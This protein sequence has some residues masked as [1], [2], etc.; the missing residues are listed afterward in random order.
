ML[1]VFIETN[2]VVDYAAPAHYRDSTAVQ[3]LE[4]AR[5][6][7]FRLHL[8]SIC[9]SE[10]RPP[11]RDKPQS[12]HVTTIR[13]FLKWAGKH[14]LVAA[15]DGDATRRVLNLFQG[16]V[17]ADLDELDHT[18]ESLAR[19]S[20]LDVFPLDT[21]MLE[22]TISLTFEKL[23]LGPFDQAVLAAVLVRSEVLRSE[24]ETEFA[25]CELDA[26]LQPWDKEN[27]RKEPLASLYDAAYVWV[28]GDFALK[29]PQQPGGWPGTAASER[30]PVDN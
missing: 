25:F 2:W 30:R 8:P 10:A 20:A 28:Y 14:A 15:E 23:V 18:L 26:H 21:A 22:K 17:R 24:G 27:N 11:I 6:G 13:D 3:L 7:E 19:E 1:H 16:R 5:S 12:R 4:R 9:L 29:A